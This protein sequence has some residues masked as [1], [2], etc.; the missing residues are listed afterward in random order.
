MGAEALSLSGS[1]T[2]GSGAL[3]N[4]SGDNTWAG[5]ITIANAP[6]LTRINSDSGLLTINGNISEAGGST[7]FV[8]F[9]GAGNVTV[10]GAIT[11][12]GNDLGLTKDGAGTLTLANANNWGRATT[13]NGGVLLLTHATALPGGIG[14]SGGSTALAING[15]VL[16]LGA[17]G[18][19]RNLGTG[20]SQVQFIG[21]GGFAAYG[22]DRIVNLGATAPVT[23]GS[24]SFL[25]T[26]STFILGA[27]GADRTVTFQNPIALGTAAR[28]IQVENGSAAVDAI[29]SGVLSGA[30]ALNKTGA[31]TI[32]LTGVNTYTGN[33]TVNAGTLTA[34][35]T[36]GSALGFT[37]AITV[38]APGNLTLGASNQINNTASLTLA[39]GTF[40][41]G[42]FSEGSTTG[43]GSGALNLTAAGPRI[44]FGTGT[45]GTLAFS[46]FNPGVHSLLIDN[47]T[48][49]ANTI[50]TGTTDRLIFAS[51]Q[52][53]NL[54]D[55]LFAGYETGAV[56]FNLG[57]GF[58]EVTPMT[59]IPEANPALIAS[60]FCAAGIWFARRRRR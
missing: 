28:T 33:T 6:A 43:A 57:G 32:I 10:N 26:G 1:G 40:S 60:C 41:K 5:D 36:S 7:K 22:A 27:S 23:W 16:G 39:G 51:D 18:F 58:F 48:G 24:G 11:Q 44:D 30:G 38:N 25:P 15:G 3:R 13:L 59:V 8:T 46:I 35:A 49:V 31:G 20:T 50:G 17:G 34:A 19:S 14:S 4:L 47:W 55:F 9:G 56:Q 42:N 12:S 2:S 45:V 54:S 52:T 37:A 29:L 21:S 53:A